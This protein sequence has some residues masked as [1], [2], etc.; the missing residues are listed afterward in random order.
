[1]S[2]HVG[3]LTSAYVLTADERYAAHALRHLRAW[4][5]EDATRMSPHLRYAQAIHGRV[6]GRG[7]GIIDTVHLVEVA[8]SVEILARATSARADDVAAVKRWFAEYLTWLTTHEY[9]VAERDAKNNHATC[10]VVQ[11]AAF[12]RLTAHASLLDDCRRRFKDVILPGQMAA[13]GSF[14]LEIARTKPYGYSLFNL[15]ALATICQLLSTPAEDLWRFELADGRGIRRGLAYLFPFIRD[16]ATWPHARDVM[17]FE[18]WPVRSPSLLFGG[19]APA[20]ANYLTL[21]ASLPVPGDVEEVIRN[22]PIRHP[23]LWVEGAAFRR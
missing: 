16:K 4:F 17:Y 22:V 15:D 18:Q 19:I 20:E 10:W 1:M 21:W 5:V 2:T 23:L 12:A 8:R 3:T 14:P 6:T 9:G 13:D 7:V 11:V